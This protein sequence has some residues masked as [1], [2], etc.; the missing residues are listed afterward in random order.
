MP[1]VVL[2]KLGGSLLTDK[3][4]VDAFRSALAR[5]L[6]RELDGITDLVLVHGAGGFGH[7]HVKA[8]NLGTGPFTAKRQAAAKRTTE[9]LA[10]LEALVAAAAPADMPLAQIPLSNA[11][12]ANG[13]LTGF[14]LRHV[15]A[16][17]AAG[18]I[19][20]LHGSLILD[21]GAGVS[22][23]G[24]DEI[25]ARLAKAL[26]PTR[27]VF[28][29]DV[30]GVFDRD[31]REKGAR[32]FLQLGPAA[33]AARE[34]TSRAVVSRSGKG[35]DVTGRMQG[36]LAHARRAARVAPTLVVNGRVAGR[37]AAAA[38]GRRVRGTRILS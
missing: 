9:A 28:A 38:R 1:G 18:E 13:R 37:V 22:V 10:E 29:T 24:G 8:G 5:R 23:L 16:A 17:L 4:K 21:D 12:R 32:L 2:V 20:V 7:P 25:M 26:K 34:G 19:P 35:H 30:D 33:D 3:R 11:R 6:L 27:V 15:K 36:K 31:P 14:P